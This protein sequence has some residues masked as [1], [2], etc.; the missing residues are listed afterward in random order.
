M[1]SASK[2]QVKIEEKGSKL[3]VSSATNTTPKTEAPKGNMWWKKEAPP[4]KL[5]CEILT[6]NDSRDPSYTNLTL[7][8]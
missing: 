3:K 1:E 4:P 2:E 8:Q 7:P 5:P 6:P